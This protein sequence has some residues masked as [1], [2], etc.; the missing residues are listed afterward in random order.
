MKELS[1]PG[2]AQGCSRESNRFFDREPYDPRFCY[3]LF[4]RALEENN[5]MAW[6]FLFDQYRPLVASWVQRQPAFGYSGEEL[7]YFVNGAFTRLMKAIP[8]SRFPSFKN[9]KKILRYLQLCTTSELNDHLRSFKGEEPHSLEE[10]SVPLD[11]APDDVEKSAIELS[12]R[13]A[14]WALVRACARSE[15][16]FLVLYASYRLGLKPRQIYE[17]F[18]EQFSNVD[19]IYRIKENFLARLRRDPQLRAL[20]DGDDA[21]SLPRNE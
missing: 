10:A 8:P 15:S 17:R 6:R 2:L 7:D 19:R 16:E 13:N 4:R 5:Q 14:L 11:V 21:D 3:E 9:L 12:E 18:P 1:L 20:F